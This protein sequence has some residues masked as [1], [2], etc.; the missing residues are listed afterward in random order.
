M[1]I[2]IATAVALAVL[3]GSANA[4]VLPHPKGCP[5]YK[6]CGCGV[7][8]RVFGRAI[9]QGTYAVAGY[10][11]R[12]PR[13]SPAPG[14]VAA[15]SRHVFYIESVFP[16]GTVMAYDPNSGGHL[17][18]RHRVSLSGYRVVNPHAN[19]YSAR[20]VPDSSQSTW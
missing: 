12:F 4:E 7:A 11:L 20:T 17:T 1:R 16:D 13:T 3:S 10:W 19:R 2:A 5:T 9:R 18:R 6:F 8:L 15:N 14:M